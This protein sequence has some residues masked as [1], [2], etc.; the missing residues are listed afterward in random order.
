MY[1]VRLVVIMIVVV[2][3]LVYFPLKVHFTLVM[4]AFYKQ[5]RDQINA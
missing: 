5:K 4:R 3:S 1:N 2:S